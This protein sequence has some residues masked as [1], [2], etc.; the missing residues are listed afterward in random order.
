MV[1]RV[2]SGHVG[3]RRV[4][5]ISASPPDT[6]HQPARAAHDSHVPAAAMLQAR[7]S[8]SAP[9]SSRASAEVRHS[10]RSCS[11]PVARARRRRR[12][13]CRLPCPRSACCVLEMLIVASGYTW[14]RPLLLKRF[15]LAKRSG[16]PREGTAFKT[17]AISAAASR[18]CLQS[19]PPVAASRR[20]LQPSLVR[21]KAARVHDGTAALL[22]QLEASYM[23]RMHHTALPSDSPLQSHWRPWRPETGGLRPGSAGFRSRA[24]R[25]Q[26]PGCWQSLAW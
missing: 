24:P 23:S 15:A 26:G 12:L 11:Q 3:S 7:P 16:I 8:G 21:I 4:T 20:C 22:A 9:G 2:T 18:R 1:A 6:P 19:L 17:R 5:A 13:P 25:K 10:R 14:M